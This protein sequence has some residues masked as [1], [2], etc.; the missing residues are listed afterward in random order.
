M[1]IR[2]LVV[3]QQGTREPMRVELAVDHQ[4]A[5]VVPAGNVDALADAIATMLDDA[6][7]RAALVSDA[8]RRVRDGHE[9]HTNTKQL[10]ALFETVVDH[11]R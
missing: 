3:V 2:G 11:G 4:S 9:L 8:A 6:S 5:L 1:R 7:L 10:A